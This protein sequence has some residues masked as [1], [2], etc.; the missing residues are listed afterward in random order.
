MDVLINATD[1][2]FLSCDPPPSLSGSTQFQA[3]PSEESAVPFRAP[4]REMYKTAFGHG[5]PTVPTW[6]CLSV[7]IIQAQT[8]LYASLFLHFSRLSLPYA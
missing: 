4:L 2:S 1:Q 7:V 8:I 6:S 5:V 3:D